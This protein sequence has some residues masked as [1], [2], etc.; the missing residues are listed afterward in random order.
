MAKR[1]VSVLGTAL[2][3]VG[4]FI[5]IWPFISV[6]RVSSQSLNE[7]PEF[8]EVVMEDDARGAFA[9][10]DRDEFTL[11]TRTYLAADLAKVEAELLAEG[12]E[13]FHGRTPRGNGFTKRCCGDYDALVVRLTSSGQN[14]VATATAS[15]GD[16]TVTWPLLVILGAPVLLLGVAITAM[17]RAF[18][19]EEESSELQLV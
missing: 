10:F 2:G 15:D 14:T 5:M 13:V 11:S 9:I 18:S 12:F 8:A 1:A 7:L 16:V 17:G 4:L 6:A 3:L 19:V